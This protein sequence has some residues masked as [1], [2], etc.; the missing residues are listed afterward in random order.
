MVDRGN[1]M[2]QYLTKYFETR[3]YDVKNINDLPEGE[4][5]VALRAKEAFSGT[6]SK[7]NIERGNS[8]TIPV[9][10][11]QFEI[12]KTIIDDLGYAVDP[13]G[14]IKKIE[15]LDN[16]NSKSEGKVLSY[17]LPQFAEG[18]QNSDLKAA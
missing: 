8:K 18:D 16:S 4:R 13:D 7:T 10:E 14:K 6:K 3:G 2:E 5:E 11:R 17:S 12:M 1:S 9:P 15:N